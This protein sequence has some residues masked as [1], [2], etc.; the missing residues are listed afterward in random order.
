MNPS[1]DT[2]VQ[3]II[4]RVIVIKLLKSMFFEQVAALG[5]W[6][7]NWDSKLYH[8]GWTSILRCMP[9]LAANR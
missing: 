9:V 2:A 7:F 3:S 8:R 4:R 6:V 1:N 5:V